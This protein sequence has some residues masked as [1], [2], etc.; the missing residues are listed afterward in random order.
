MK[1][2]LCILLCVCLILPLLGCNQTVE[3]EKPVTYYY[4]RTE[5]SYGTSDGV[6]GSEQRESIGH[7]NDMFY[8][9][10][11]YVSG[12]HSAEFSQTFPDN[13][14]VVSV[15][16]SKKL[17]RIVF[18]YHFAEL[19]GIDLTI[20]CACITKTVMDLTG[21]DAVQI[22]AAGE[23]LDEQQTITMDRNSLLLLDESTKG[24]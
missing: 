19:T 16:R 5:V 4:R 15:H 10:A 11:Q 13:L 21:T 14:I 24:K 6:I 7:E 22:S 8:L 23:L 12:P 20:A 3:I 2:V 1:R 18:S 17:V 9:L